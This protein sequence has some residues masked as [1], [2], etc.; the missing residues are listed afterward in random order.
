MIK[1]N[2]YGGSSTLVNTFTTVMD[3]VLKKK[4][5]FYKEP[6]VW[7][8]NEADTVMG[9]IFTEWDFDLKKDKQKKLDD[10][11]KIN[12]NTPGIVPKIP[13]EK[14]PL[15]TKD[16]YD[17]R[18]AIGWLGKDLGKWPGRVLPTET[19]TIKILQQSINKKQE[20]REKSKNG[21]NYT[22]FPKLKEDGKFGPKTGEAVLGE[23]KNEGVEMLTQG[24]SSAL[25][26]IPYIGE[27]LG[28]ALGS[29]IGK[30]VLDI[31]AEQVFKE[32]GEKIGLGKNKF[33][34][35]N[36]AGQLLTAGISD[37]AES[38]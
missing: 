28:S 34:V 21:E 24:I 10:F 8:Q 32:V 33:D 6:S 3:D 19:E 13:E 4:E 27:Y 20:E 7:T 31:G 11:Y 17:M 22:V 36:V 25:S 30:V 23:L 14:S 18:E 5:P 2:N 1:F 9:D 35:G 38:G 37:F 29:N 26:S 16:G 12:Y 15:L